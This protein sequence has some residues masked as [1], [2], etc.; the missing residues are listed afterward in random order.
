MA[1][2]R[3]PSPTTAER[4]GG[5]LHPRRLRRRLP[6]AA[7]AAALVGL[8]GVLGGGPT[9]APAD[10]RVVWVAAVDVPPGSSLGPDEVTEQLVP[11]ELVP[12]DAAHSIPAGT[13]ARTRIGRGEIL[14][15]RALAG[16]G[17]PGQLDIDQRAV[18]VAWPAARPPIQVGDA[19]DLVAT[20]ASDGG[21]PTTRVVV[22]GA[23]VLALDEQGLTV[24]VPSASAL[25][26]HQ[27]AAA[28][29]IDLA[30]TPWRP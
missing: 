22:A 13:V 18:A 15:A 17:V 7:G 4:L 20:A 5:R 24:S 29:V 1:L 27:A 26:V 14:V 10:H 8:G 28:G 11:P 9:R 21:W 16:T 30:V 2:R 23:V 12:A 25:A 6:L 19:V 3:P